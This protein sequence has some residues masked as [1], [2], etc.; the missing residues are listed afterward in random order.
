MHRESSERNPGVSAQFIAPWTCLA[1]DRG[2]A[3]L[4]RVRGLEKFH[5]NAAACLSPITSACSTRFCSA[6]ALA[7]RQL[8]NPVLGDKNVWD[9]S[10]L[11]RRWH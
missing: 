10:W 8:S 9:D 7:F 6:R 1:Y 3:V 2:A 5:R 4:R 11:K